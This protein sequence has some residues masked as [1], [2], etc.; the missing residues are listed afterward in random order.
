MKNAA[1]TVLAIV[2]AFAV[3]KWYGSKSTS[4]RGQGSHNTGPWPQNQ[5]TGQGNFELTS[6]ASGV[7]A[8]DTTPV[9][10]G[11]GDQQA[12]TKHANPF[13]TINGSANYSPAFGPLEN[14]NPQT[15]VQIPV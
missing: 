8:Y 14:Q 1:I 6:V 4:P 2:G 7:P 13:S 5:N 11:H 12:A 9:E 10:A 15:T 3:F